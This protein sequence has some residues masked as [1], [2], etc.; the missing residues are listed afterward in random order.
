MFYQRIA[1]NVYT[2]SAKSEALRVTTTAIPNAPLIENISGNTVKIVAVNGYEYS[3][4]GVNWQ[5]NN[6]FTNLEENK[7]YS[8]F[9][10]TIPD[11][12]NIP[13]IIYGNKST[14][15]ALQKKNPFKENRLLI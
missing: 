5:S 6:I 9:V 4:D 12:V 8:A 15:S 10:R 2:A 14:A 7:I 11:G 3:V 13:D 1:D